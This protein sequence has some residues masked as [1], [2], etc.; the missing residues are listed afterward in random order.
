MILLLIMIVTVAKNIFVP[1][2]LNRFENGSH[3]K[4]NKVKSASKGTEKDK[5][6]CNKPK[7]GNTHEKE[8]IP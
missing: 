2:R 8:E 6:R 4:Q 3:I 7:S 5:S 1:S